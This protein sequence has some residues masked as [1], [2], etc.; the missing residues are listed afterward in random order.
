MY[1]FDSYG[2]EPPTEIHRLIERIQRQGEELETPIN[3]E[4]NKTRHQYKNSECGVYSMNFIIQL[5]EG[6][7]SFDKIQN[8]RIEDEK[9]NR[10]RK[11]FFVPDIVKN[12][13]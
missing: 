6:N 1:Y 10:K 5:L 7:K 13:S 9:M 12:E 8:E 3:Y 11:Y 2:I 4:Y